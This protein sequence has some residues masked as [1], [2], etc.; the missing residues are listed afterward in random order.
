MKR[1]E[2]LYDSFDIKHGFCFIIGSSDQ[3]IGFEFFKADGFSKNKNK[4]FFVEP[5]KAYPISY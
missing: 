2:Q 4:K 3:H 5:K 1:Q